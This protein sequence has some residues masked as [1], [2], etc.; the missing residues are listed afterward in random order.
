MRAHPLMVCRL[1]YAHEGCIQRWINEKGNRTCEICHGPFRDS[2]ADPP[3]PDPSR[4]RTIPISILPH[5]L[6]IRRTQSVRTLYL[7]QS[8]SGPDRMSATLMTITCYRTSLSSLANPP[9]IALH[10]LQR[11]S[12]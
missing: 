1:Q 7:D 2:F 5:M 11:P 8:Q 9:N 3:P 12:I 4:G 6:A 10:M